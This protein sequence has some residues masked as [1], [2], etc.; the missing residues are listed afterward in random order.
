MSKNTKIILDWNY[1]PKDFFE[2][3]TEI[4][5]NQYEMVIDN[6]KITVTL[7]GETY[8]DN[9][10]IREQ[11]NSF[12]EDRF[13]GAQLVNR[14][15]YELSKSSLCR[16]FPDGKK[17]YEASVETLG[18][19]VSVGTLDVI[20]KDAEGN[21]ISDSKQDRINKQERFAEL[22][23]KYRRLDTTAEGILV[24]FDKAVRDSVNELVHLYEIIDALKTSLMVR[25]QLDTN[26][27]L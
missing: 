12:L 22:S 8:D 13:L 9:P 21:I 1:S 14:K 25:T 2:K 7:D 11:L 4:D 3:K 10:S 19:V 24:S 26:F 6:G 5:T 17:N 18:V 27:A 20:A 16:I 23:A 15:P